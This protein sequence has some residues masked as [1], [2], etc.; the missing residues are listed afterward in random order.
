MLGDAVLN[1]LCDGVG[2]STLSGACFSVQPE[3]AR[4]RSVGTIGPLFDTLEQLNP[5]TI[6]TDGI[7]VEVGLV[8]TRG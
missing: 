6:Q 7:R 8:F 3:N 5:S 2:N 1:H 4:L